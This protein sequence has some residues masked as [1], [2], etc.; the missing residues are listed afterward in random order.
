MR[1][2]A[3]AFTSL[4]AFLC[5]SVSYGYATFIGYGYVNCMT[6]H[7]NPHGGGQ[8]N[9][10]GRALFANEIAARPP[11]NSG[12][13]D[14]ELSNHSSFLFGQPGTGS[15]KP[16]FK[17]RE[18][19]LNSSPGGSN[20]NKKYVMQADA[21][22]AFHF[23]SADKYIL[24]MSA[25]Y[26]PRPLNSD[27]KDGAWNYHLLSREHYLRV[28][29]T[30]SQFLS[31]GLIDIAYGLR[32]VDHTGANRAKIGLDQND[33]VHGVL[34]D[35]FKDQWNFG[36]HVFAGNQLRDT[37]D[38]LSGVSTTLEYELR[39]KLTVGFSALSGSTQEGKRT[40]LGLHSRTGVGKGN[41]LVAEIGTSKY[42][43]NNQDALTGA[44]SV[45][46]GTLRIVRGLDFESVF[47]LYK[48]QMEDSAEN[49]RTTFGF[50]YF[51]AQRLELRFEA[52]DDRG[53]SPTA[54]QGDTWSIASQLHLSL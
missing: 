47:E 21:G 43:A 19:Y 30:D 22:F 36:L 16:S 46:G 31:V 27:I 23:D 26:T 3:F 51:P 39:E 20:Q 49:Y 6:C 41:S 2:S 7:Y 37:V 11:W 32:L 48:P 44:Y 52:V 5:S 40:L 9:D 42:Q 38:R 12:A 17:Y 28:Q 25:G 4:I 1:L 45:I 35:Y 8:L 15:F 14:E 29:M 13:S 34:Y 18:L 24:V 53:F 54:V 10:Y 33:Q 50:I